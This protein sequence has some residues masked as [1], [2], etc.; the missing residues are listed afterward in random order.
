MTRARILLADDHDLFREG[1][2]GLIDAFAKP[3]TAAVAQP[4]PATL[5]L[6][7]RGEADAKA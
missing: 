6:S 2:A 3:A 5:D 1:L 4:A 7:N